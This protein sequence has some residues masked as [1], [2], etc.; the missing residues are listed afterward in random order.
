MRLEDNSTAENNETVTDTTSGV[1]D[2]LASMVTNI[3][4]EKPEE[5]TLDFHDYIKAKVKEIINK[6]E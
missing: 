4:N 2:K 1:N 3:I 6:G 5:A